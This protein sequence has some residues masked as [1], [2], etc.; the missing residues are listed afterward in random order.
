MW[1]DGCEVCK[2]RYAGFSLHSLCW[3]CEVKA[4]EKAETAN[5]QENPV[6]TH[7]PKR[8]ET[9]SMYFVRRAATVDTHGP[10]RYEACLAC[11]LEY[12]KLSSHSLC[13]D[14]EIEQKAA[15]DMEVELEKARVE[16]RNPLVAAL[17]HCR[18]T[19]EDLYV[20]TNALSSRHAM[21]EKTL[22]A[23]REALEGIK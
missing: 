3:N 16:A 15:A 7:G 14:C 8:Y 6:D 9:C 20:C 10:K 1:Y 12:T 4:K 13:L 22:D 19:L 18:S 21:I 17:Q 2:Q 11:G 23:I 5:K